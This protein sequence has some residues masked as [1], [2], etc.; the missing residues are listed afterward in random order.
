MTQRS[1]ATALTR[2]L[3][4]SRTLS[5][6]NSILCTTKQSFYINLFPISILLAICLYRSSDCT[7]VSGIVISVC[8]RSQIRTSKCTCNFW[9]E[10]WSWP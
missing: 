7:V 2:D 6:R 4:T 3:Q 10:Y 9:C 5:K 1:A 8:N